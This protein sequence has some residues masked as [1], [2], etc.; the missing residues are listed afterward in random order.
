MKIEIIEK[1]IK[2]PKVIQKEP[3]EEKFNIYEKYT[4]AISNSE[5]PLRVTNLPFY[6]DVYCS[7]SNIFGSPI[8]VEPS[9]SALKNPSHMTTLEPFQTYSEFKPEDNFGNDPFSMEHDS[10]FN[11]INSTN[12]DIDYKK[13]SNQP[14][15][16]V[17]KQRIIQIDKNKD[18][19]NMAI[20]ILLIVILLLNY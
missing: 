13:F 7:T 4:N 17:I 5:S 12:K 14:E 16:K 11:T 1:K 9:T 6:S 19:V 2:V 15:T 3:V 20:I 10:Y 18:Y 8:Y